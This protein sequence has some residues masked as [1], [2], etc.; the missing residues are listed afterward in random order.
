M[1]KYLTKEQIMKGMLFKSGWFTLGAPITDTVM[2]LLGE[3]KVFSY[4]GTRSG[5]ASDA[6]MGSPSIA[7][8]NALAGTAKSLIAPVFNP[9]YQYS[10]QDWR[11]I[12]TLA[13]LHGLLGWGNA[14]DSVPKWLDLPDSST[15][16]E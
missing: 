9:S 6:L 15:V 13:P 2:Q 3:D 5:L 12:K 16:K 7:I 14:L 4:A 1:K 10:K 8:A 11:N